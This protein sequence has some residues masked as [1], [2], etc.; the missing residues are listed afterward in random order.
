[1]QKT[2]LGDGQARV[3]VEKHDHNAGA[4]NCLSSDGQSRAGSFFAGLRRSA[5]QKKEA[6]NERPLT[7]RIF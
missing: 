1:M 5:Q 6:L 3:A 4:V 7:V 2:C